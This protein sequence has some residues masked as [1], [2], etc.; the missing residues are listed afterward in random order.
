M[1]KG[2][3]FRPGIYSKNPRFNYLPDS[4]R[5]LSAQEPPRYRFNII[6]VGTNGQEHLRVTLLEGRATIHGVYDPN[7]G[8]IGWRN[9]ILPIMSK[10]A[11]CWCMTRYPQLA[12]IR[13][14]MG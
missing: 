14:W 7:P 2:K 11:S 8:S 4:D 5:Y 9:N 3:E 10:I 6:G 13:R 1:A 12:T